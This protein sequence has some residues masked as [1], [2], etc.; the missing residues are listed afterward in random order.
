MLW[1]GRAK[2]YESHKEGVSNM[3]KY[4]LSTMKYN[5]SL[6][7][8]MLRKETFTFKMESKE[9]TASCPFLA[10]GDLPVKFIHRYLYVWLNLRNGTVQVFFYLRQQL[11]KGEKRRLFK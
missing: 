5:C 8:L 4:T 6:L 11:R 7:K 3:L 10:I 1:A 9:L 2:C